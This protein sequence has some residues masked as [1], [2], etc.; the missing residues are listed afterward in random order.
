MTTTTSRTFRPFLPGQMLATPG[1]LAAFKDCHETLPAILG[2]HM[3]ET[4]AT[5][6]KTMPAS[7]TPRPSTAA[8]SCRPTAAHGHPRLD[9]HRGRGRQR[10]ASGD[11]RP[12]ARGILIS[13]TPQRTAGGRVPAGVCLSRH[14]LFQGAYSGRTNPSQFSRRHCPWIEESPVAAIAFPWAASRSCSKGPQ[15]KRTSAWSKRSMPWPATSTTSR[16]STFAM[17][18]RSRFAPSSSDQSCFETRAR[19]KSGP[20]RFSFVRSNPMSQKWRQIAR[21]IGVPWEAVKAVYQ[22]LKDADRE[23]HER[24]REIRR[25]AWHMHKANTPGCWPFWRTVFKP[26]TASDT[27]LAT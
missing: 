11:D 22:Q 7:T 27:P 20:C 6:A 19:R 24:P 3:K 5:S 21:E 2:R 17:R 9:H 25:T 15:S 4:G 12:A 13:R 26:T 10:P 8:A 16:T 18:R 14:S 1:A 23:Q